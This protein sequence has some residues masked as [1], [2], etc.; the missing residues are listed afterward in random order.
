MTSTKTQYTRPTLTHQGSVEA[1]T[2]G[3]QEGSYSDT[4]ICPMCWKAYP[5]DA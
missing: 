3:Y 5:D 2:L 4:G 1:R